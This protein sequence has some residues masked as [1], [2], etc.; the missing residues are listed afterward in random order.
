M[1]PIRSVL[2]DYD[3]RCLA[4]F[5]EHMALNGTEHLQ[6]NELMDYMESIV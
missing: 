5:L 4:H 6:G 2:E 3:Q 1:L